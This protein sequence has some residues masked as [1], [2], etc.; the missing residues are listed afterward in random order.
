MANVIKHKRGSGSDP[1]ASD[2]VVG[3]L[4][5]RTDT[6]KLFTKM[7]SGALAEIAGGGSDI[8]INTLSSSSG[9][10]GGSAT[11]NGS[12]YR[13][14]LSSPPAVSA[15][16]LLVSINGVIQKP[17]AGTG[18]PSEGFSVDGNDIILGD[19]PAAGSDFFI[20]TFRSLGVSVPADNSVTSAKIVD[21]T[22]VNADI[23]ASAAIAGSKISPTFTSSV[24]A[25]NLQISHTAPLITFTDTNANS[26]FQIKVD[27]G[28]M[29]LRDQTNSADRLVIN[30]SGNVGIGTTSPSAKLHVVESTSTAAVKIK[31]GTS[32]NQNACLTFLNDNE[33]GL[34][35]LG[36][37]GS[38]A[39][40][41]GAN[42][43]TD[44]FI[45]ANNQLSINAQNNSGQIRFGIGSTPNTKMLLD[46]SGRLIVGSTSIS[47]NGK[48]QG[49]I[50]HGSTAGE[51]G[52][53]SVDTTA[54][55]AGVGGEISFMA[56]TNTSGDYNYVGHVR[57]IKEN[58]TSGNTA[59]ALT[60]HTRPTLTAP[61]ERMRID[62]SGRVMMNTTTFSL[63]K[64]PMLE[65]RSDSNTAADFGAVFS[66][67]NQTSAIGISYNQIDSFNN[68]NNADLH[69]L[70]N[71]TE[72][73]RID[74]SGTV[75]IS[76]SRSGASI[77]DATLRFNI[78]NS[79]GD[80]K[81]AQIIST[82]IADIS[83]TIEFGTT[84][85]H[86]Y[87]ERMRIHSDG[88]VGI[89]TAVPA[90]RLHLHDDSSDSIY[91]AVTNS[92]TGTSTS[93]G[94]LFGFNSGEQAIIWNFEN[95]A[96]KFATNGTERALIKNDGRVAIN[97][98]ILANGADEY[99]GFVSMKPNHIFNN[100]AEDL[101]TSATQSTL[102]VRTSSN[103]SM[104]L[105]IGGLDNSIDSAR[106]Y[107]QVGNLAG[108]SGATAFYD[109]YLCP[110]G[111]IV[112]TRQIIPKD[113][114][115]YDLGS[116]ANR[117][118][119][120][121]ATNGTIQTSDRNEKNTIVDS[122]LG[123]SFINKLKPVSYKFNGKT[124]THYGLISQDV[125]T[126]LSDISKST[127]DFAGFIKSVVSDVLY[128]EDEPLPDDKKVGDVKTPGSTT[129]G[130]RYAEFIAPLIKAVQELSAK[131]EALEA[132]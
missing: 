71:G 76:G 98:D 119:D 64:S 3:E 124:R 1:G 89:G 86:A 28:L 56:K 26:D 39:T 123:L 42:E 114:D 104:S 2:L 66:S 20:L 110:F 55:A 118:D 54:M 88:N 99:G 70:T 43:A 120:V 11:F 58:A 101:A 8:A 65:V 122:D 17:V 49:F 109:L 107:L 102:R 51:S 105:Y 36:V 12:A 31:C 59:C 116:S 9:T 44:A 131:V 82:K 57:G 18:Q 40:T 97:T 30:S 68:N 130:L 27:G 13:F 90:R 15:Q 87:A 63:S 29:S 45:T 113:D 35:H 96:L 73:M 7:D 93:D 10:G 6:G 25:P 117:W 85:S 16:Q 78:V 52:I 132:K 126:V 92:T 125:E 83:S 22:I 80:E 53:T 95:T 41:F 34:L 61:I 127:T 129:Y 48:I 81:K 79:N 84:V 32:T 94:V 112:R 108:A 37:F 74:S 91:L 33:G 14:T 24:V 5:I 47:N 67:N 100:N 111:G 38:S 21:G 60:F 75:F 46:S 69:L 72:R 77:S 62:S 115:S 103:S 23:N 19:A 106:P 121:F 4:A 128:T 50:A